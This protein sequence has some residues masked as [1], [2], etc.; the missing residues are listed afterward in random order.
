MQGKPCLIANII[1]LQHKRPGMCQ[2]TILNDGIDDSQK[3]KSPVTSS[4]FLF[5]AT[6]MEYFMWIQW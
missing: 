4:S 5:A 3:G 1:T 2:H 6:R